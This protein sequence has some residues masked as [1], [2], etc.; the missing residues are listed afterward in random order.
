MWSLFLLAFLICALYNYIIAGGDLVF[1]SRVVETFNSF[2]E[3]TP[4]AIRSTSHS[5]V[6]EF[7]FGKRLYGLMIP[8]KHVMP[9]TTVAAL[10]EDKWTDVTPEVEYWAGPFKNFYGIPLKPQHINDT[11]EKIAFAFPGDK[12]VHVP[13]NQIIILFLRKA[14][15]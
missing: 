11:W 10:I 7:K 9:W 2:R 3:P 1:F 14:S 15:E 13:S 4:R 8:K 5:L 6:H 12:I